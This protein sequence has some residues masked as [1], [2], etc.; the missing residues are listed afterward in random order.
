MDKS[1][2]AARRNKLLALLSE[3]AAIIKAGDSKIRSHDTEYEFRVD[4]NFYYLTGFLEP[5]SILLLLPKHDK[6]RSVLFIRPKDPLK[7]TWTGIRMGVEKAQAELGID[8]IF[9]L[10]DFEKELPNLLT[11]HTKVYLDLF[12]QINFAQK[13]IEI[14][15]NLARTLSRQKQKFAPREI[16]D[17][18]PI[19]GK[20]RLIKEPVEILAMKKAHSLSAT[21]HLM[22]MSYAKPQMKEYELKALLEYY[23]AKHGGT[24]AYGS[25]IA[26]GD[27]ANILHYI[28]NNDTI[29]DG[30]LI[31]VDAGCEL[32]CYSSDI[33]RT[34]PVSK[35]FSGPQKVI[36]ELVLEAQKKAI[37]ICAPGKHLIDDIH[38]MATKTL[39][40]GLIHLKLLTGSVDQIIEK[41]E[42]KKFYPHGTCHWMGI[43]V[44]DNNPYYDERG[45][46]ILLRPGMVFS[47]EP[48]LYFPASDTT[49]PSEFRGIGVRIEDDIA[50]TDSSF[51]NLTKDLA[52]EVNDIQEACRKDFRELQVL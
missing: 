22:L 13:M 33:T 24:T 46:D 50:I 32:D 41:G 20:Q 11:N 4:S 39:V 6:Y 21:A 42:H 38:M 26:S 37:S 44:H 14:C 19:I 49:I 5:E 17:I 9:S 25:I 31:L 47:V 30:D 10:D 2:F 18:I 16:S 7:E 52:K 8:K 15:K 40:E 12:N 1:L 36:Y 35:T 27:H 23:F 45:N 28:E 51:D 48:G 3:G 43:D 29:K 34:F